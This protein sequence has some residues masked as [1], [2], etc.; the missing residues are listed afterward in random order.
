MH[1]NEYG[2]RVPFIMN[3]P[4]IIKKRGMTSIDGVLGYIHYID[5][6]FRGGVA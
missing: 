6:F 3:S 5:G 1:A 4:D 2:P